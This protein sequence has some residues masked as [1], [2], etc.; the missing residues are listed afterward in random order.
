MTCLIGT[1]AVIVRASADLHSAKVMDLKEG[2]QI[3]VV[4]SKALPDGTIRVAVALA[5][6]PESTLGWITGCKED[7]T[8]NLQVAGEDGLHLLS[9]APK[10]NG[11]SRPPSLSVLLHGR[12]QQGAAVCMQRVQRGRSGRN[13]LADAAAQPGAA[14]APK[15]K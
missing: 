12:N 4:D 15:G 13:L 1:R 7:G 3:V 9:S 8:E 10:S 6:A 2:E 11:A 5:S 14:G